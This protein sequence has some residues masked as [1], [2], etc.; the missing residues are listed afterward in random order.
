MQTRRVDFSVDFGWHA[1][2]RCAFVTRPVDLDSMIYYTVCHLPHLHR[3]KKPFCISYRISYSFLNDCVLIFLVF[4][5][6]LRNRIA[7]IIRVFR[8][9]TAHVVKYYTSWINKT[10]SRRSHRL[11][12]RGRPAKTPLT[13]IRVDRSTARRRAHKTSN[14][15]SGRQPVDFSL[16]PNAVHA[17]QSNRLG[18]RAE[19]NVRARRGEK[20][21]AHLLFRHIIVTRND[22]RSEPGRRKRNRLFVLSH[23]YALVFQRYA[24]FDIADFDWR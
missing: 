10:N 14:T 22:I 13:E 4:F 11:R 1:A 8:Q 5:S 20:I 17:V 19:Q 18:Y 15:S 16:N 12:N 2:V 6:A 21:K 7:E 9:Y 24:R 3:K 23:T